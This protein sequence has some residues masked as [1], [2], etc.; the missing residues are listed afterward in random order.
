M[1]VK[2]RGV[3]P[4]DSAKTSA[5]SKGGALGPER[6]CVRRRVEEAVVP[7]QPESGVGSAPGP[8]GQPED[9]ANAV[10]SNSDDA[11]VEVGGLE[12]DEGQG[13]IDD[14]CLDNL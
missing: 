1:M 5:G 3:V 2:S 11:P 4:D 14:P 7:R 6:I 9:D 12:L 13:A 10:E 8:G